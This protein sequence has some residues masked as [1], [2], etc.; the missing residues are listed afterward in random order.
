MR[1]WDIGSKVGG[2]V[3]EFVDGL[4]ARKDS[5]H[6]PSL[7]EPRVKGAVTFFKID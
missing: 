1:G 3:V 4:R 5:R 7:A 2:I 6:G